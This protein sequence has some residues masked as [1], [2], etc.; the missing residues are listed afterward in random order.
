MTLR[1]RTR[2]NEG[3]AP[4]NTSGRTNAQATVTPSQQRN[5]S[6]GEPVGD[7]LYAS[8]VRRRD[9]SPHPSTP[10][11]EDDTEEYADADSGRTSPESEDEDDAVPEG[12]TRTRRSAKKE[13][14]EQRLLTPRILSDELV[15]PFRADQGLVEPDDPGDFEYTNRMVIVSSAIEGMSGEQWETFARRL[16]NVRVGSDGPIDSSDDSDRTHRESS[17][18]KAERKAERIR[19][20]EERRREK[21]LADENVQPE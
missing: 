7:P 2:T 6:A 13:T 21:G 3:T 20:R 1:P 9:D 17:K 10:H 11:R 16:R 5:D 8:D 4:S 18:S 19:R 12:F 15:S 14:R